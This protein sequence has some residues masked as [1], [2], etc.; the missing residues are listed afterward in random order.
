MVLYKHNTTIIECW[1]WSRLSTIVNIH[2]ASTGQKRTI[3][4]KSCRYERPQL[5]LYVMRKHENGARETMICTKL[6]I[7]RDRLTFPFSLSFLTLRLNHHLYFC[8]AFWKHIKDTLCYCIIRLLCLNSQCCELHHG[9]RDQKAKVMQRVGRGVARQGQGGGGKKKP[10]TRAFSIHWARSSSS[11]VLQQLPA[12]L[13]S[14]NKPS[15]KVKETYKKDIMQTVISQDPA[16]PQIEWHN[17]LCS[18]SIWEWITE[19]C[20]VFLHDC[21]M[22]SVWAIYTLWHGVLCEYKNQKTASQIA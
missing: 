1:L 2:G 12:R 9:N 13:V 3:L 8:S 21:L 22:N 5:V 15:A 11:P 18:F 20:N 16:E 7:C 17:H 19:R 10:S 14:V 4:K 6:T